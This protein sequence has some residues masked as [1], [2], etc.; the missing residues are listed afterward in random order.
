MK[1]HLLIIIFF[2]STVL[3]GQEKFEAPK[4]DNQN[5]WSIIVIPDTQNYVKW[6]RNQ[7]ILDLMVRWIEDN[8][9]KLNIKMVAHVGDL[10]EH[11]N[12]LNPGYDGDQSAESQ[13]KSIQSTLGRL[14]GKVPYIAAT[15]NHDFSINNEGRRFSR[16]NDFF[17]SDFNNLN[18]KYLAQNFYNDAGAPSME[19]SVFEL[20]NLNGID[21]LFFN[22]EYAPRNITLEWAKK[23]IEMPQYK[24][25]RSILITHAFL[26]NKDQRT[27][28]QNSWFMYEPFVIDDIPQK[29][30]TI[31]LPESNNGE[32]IWQKLVAQSANMQLVISGH[33]S[34]EGFRTDSNNF[35]KPANQML[36]DMQSEGGGHRNGNG[37]DGWLRILEFYPDN[38]TVKVKTY[39]PLFGI[40][41]ST[42]KYAYKKDS[43]NEFIFTLAN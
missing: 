13:W 17:P 22:L 5:S 42:Q 39:S 35:G 15:G 27:S 32:E 23:I 43:R 3:S 37:G 7:P 26:D 12:I 4:L 11:N 19:N 29:S 9:D 18:Q 6:N 41:P 31:N 33:I 25:H 36:F 20:K 38:K 1:K 28:K 14:N 21:Y 2:I 34:G 10:V 16:Y 30:K 40:S 24:N 8:I